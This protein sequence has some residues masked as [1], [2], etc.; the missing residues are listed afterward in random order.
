MK[1]IEP[2]NEV[3]D[4]DDYPPKNNL[5][6]VDEV[7]P[8][9]PGAKI[10]M[11]GR[12]RVGFVMPSAI[13]GLD[14]TLA[15]VLR[16]MRTWPMRLDYTAAPEP[17]GV[18]RPRPDLS[19]KL[20]FNRDWLKAITSS[21]SWTAMSELVSSTLAAMGTRGL[22]ALVDAAARRLSARAAD[23]LMAGD[24]QLN[25]V[26]TDALRSEVNAIVARQP[27]LGV[28]GGRELV[29]AA[30]SMAATAGL[31]ASGSPFDFSLGTIPLIPFLPILMTPHEPGP[32]VTALELPYRVILS[33]LT[34]ARWLH[35]DD[36]FE[37]SGRTE[38]WHTRLTTAANDFGPDAPAKV[39]A[40]WTPDYD[41]WEP[42]FGIDEFLPLL[43]PPPKPFRMSLDPLDRAMLVRLMANFTDTLPFGRPYQPRA[44]RA[45][46]LQLS[47]LGGSL[48]VEGNWKERPVDVDL[49][50]WRHIASLGR[51][52]Y[53]RV[54]Y[55]GFLCAL[56]HAASLIK[57]TERKFESLG[58][59]IRQQR[60]AVLRQSF[61]IVT[62]ERIKE[63]IGTEP[64]VR[65]QEL[66]IQ[67]GGDPDPRDTQTDRSG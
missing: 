24:R 18:L 7:V 47:A 60:V 54:V 51:D 62:R 12:S 38:L 67:T 48:D 8:P 55:T 28:E 52:Q 45:R 61:Y 50:Q 46:K 26:L 58:A 35:R 36:T 44:S 5:P 23:G 3:S 53:V 32:G 41:S 17:R 37:S 15:E 64:Q 27:R 33:P 43:E 63:Y 4:H 40:I 56:P 1:K 65:R 11:A 6:S 10:R 31:S 42:Q 16:A 22:D 9:L 14:Y 25:A 59:D 19:E 2:E 20:D 30:I 21:Q 49:E 57:V 29:T 39:R 13:A 66:S 34:P